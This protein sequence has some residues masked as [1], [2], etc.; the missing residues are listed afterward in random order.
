M[1]V[2][3]FNQQLWGIRTFNEVGY[4]KESNL[5]SVFFLD[6]SEM[7]FSNVEELV[8]FEFIITLEKEDFLKKVFLPYYPYIHKTKKLSELS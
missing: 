5:F 1:K 7:Q 8:V 6:G 2:T 3:K 4:D